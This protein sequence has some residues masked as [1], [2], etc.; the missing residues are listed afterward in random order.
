M[1]GLAPYMNGLMKSFKQLDPQL[2]YSGIVYRRCRLTSTQLDFYQE[3]TIFIWSA[4]TSTTIEFRAG[5][6]DTFGRSLF[7]ITIPEDKKQYA[8]QLESVSAVPTEREVLLLPN[9]AYEVMAVK[10][11]LDVQYENVEVVI[12]L[13]V[14]Y[15]C[16]S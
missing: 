4:F 6:V 1:E 2:F 15:V 14:S 9:I 3:E 16:I 13:S 5:D 12:E 8:I 7:I 10:K 11:G